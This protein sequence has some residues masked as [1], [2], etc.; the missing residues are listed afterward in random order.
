M[1]ADWFSVRFFF[2]YLF[3]A[4]EGWSVDLLVGGWMSWLIR[5]SGTVLVQYHARLEWASE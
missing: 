5:A 2:F 1:F 3:F 4:G